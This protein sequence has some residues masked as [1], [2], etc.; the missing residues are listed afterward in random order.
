MVVERPELGEIPV[1]L[2][3][4][5]SEYLLVLQRAVAVD[6]VRPAD[7]LL[8]K[9]RTS[10]LQKS[11][12]RR[13]AN[14]DVV[15]AVRVFERTLRGIRSHELLG[16]ERGEKIGD[17][18]LQRVR[19]ELL[20]G[21]F[22]EHI[23]GDCRRLDH[24]ALLAG[25]RV[26]AGREQRLD[27]RRDS[28]VAEPVRGAP[29]F[30]FQDQK[31]VVDQH[32]EE[33]LDEERVSLG[34]FDDVGPD[35]FVEIGASDQILDHLL[36]LLGRQRLEQDVGGVRPFRPRRPLL[37]QRWSCIAQDHDRRSLECVRQVLDEIQERVLGPVQILERHDERTIHGQERQQLPHTPEQLLHGELRLREAH[38][39]GN[40]LDDVRVVRAEQRRELAPG[41]VGIVTVG[42][43]GCLANDLDNRPE[44][45]PVAVGET[46]SVECEGGAADAA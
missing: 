31:P 4:V 20:D 29:V 8:V 7:E 15:E 26:E 32:R 41:G 10:A 6:A 40:A 21:T 38:G 42:D 1:R 9:R 16:A 18:I 28:E 19:S 33:L 44:S 36:A 5:V 39:R 23:A 24:G 43:T 37:Q 27:R 3:E 17:L 12:V 30:V 35:A 45:H 25:E 34:R 46:A 2:L 13:F 11:V 22:G 14:E